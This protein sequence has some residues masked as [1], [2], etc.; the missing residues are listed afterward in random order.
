MQRHFLIFLLLFCQNILFEN[1]LAQATKKTAEA[2]FNS[3]R[4][5]LFVYI[6]LRYKPTIY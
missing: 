6:S 4:L 1:T 2:S 5:L 3:L